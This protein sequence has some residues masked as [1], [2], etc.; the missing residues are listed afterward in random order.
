MSPRT[1]RPTDA[2]KNHDLK[3]RVDDKLYAMYGRPY[4]KSLCHAWSASPIYFMGAF[5]LGVVSTDVAYRTYEVR[6]DL[7]T[8]KSIE[9]KVPVPG[10]YIYVKAD[11]KRVEVLSDIPGGRLIIGEQKYPI[12]EKK[13]MIVEY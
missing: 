7:G 3:V 12:I 2:L 10:G 9:G 6:P 5:R 8:L 4:E 13:K 1:G 11:R